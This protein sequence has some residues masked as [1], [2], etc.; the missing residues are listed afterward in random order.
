VGRLPFRE[1][2]KAIERFGERVAPVIR[3]ETSNDVATG[4][5]R[6]QAP[7]SIVESSEGEELAVAEA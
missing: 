7:A 5:D 4:T 2:A 1:V 3:A 6:M